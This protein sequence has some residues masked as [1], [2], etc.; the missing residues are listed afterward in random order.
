MDIITELSGMDSKYRISSKFAAAEIVRSGQF[1]FDIVFEKSLAGGKLGERCAEACARAAREKPEFAQKRAKEIINTILKEPEGNLKYF[2]CDALINIRVPKAKSIKCA[3]VIRQWL[4]SEKTKGPK[5][6]YL[7][8]IA[9][10]AARNPAVVPIADELIEEALKS[11]VPSYSARAR[12]IVVR[13][14]KNKARI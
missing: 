2:L 8:A 4:A 7:E 12:L 1:L 13:L 3:K 11:P 14:K 9:S 6:C 5:A 10:L